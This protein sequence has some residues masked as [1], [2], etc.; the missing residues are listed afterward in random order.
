[1]VPSNCSNGLNG[2]EN[3]MG[4][5]C[6]PEWCEFCGGTGCASIPG[7]EEGDCCASSIVDSGVYCVEGEEAPC[8]LVNDTNTPAPTVTA[9]PFSSP[10][11]IDGGSN[12]LED[13]R[14]LDAVT[15]QCFDK[16]KPA[17][18]NS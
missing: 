13:R 17:M 15:L 7:A 12:Y 10:I 2:V 6:C 9:L 14:T 18:T 16:F 8:I 11:P 1:M 4:T 3:A 5:V